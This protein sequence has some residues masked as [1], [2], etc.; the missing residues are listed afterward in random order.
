[1]LETPS[2]EA[3]LHSI[4]DRLASPQEVLARIAYL[5]DHSDEETCI[6]QVNCEK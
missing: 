4:E 6:R 2:D 1:V 3:A 5:Y